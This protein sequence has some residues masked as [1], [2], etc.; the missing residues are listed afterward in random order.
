M[1]RAAKSN[2]QGRKGGER[3]DY[4][5][6]KVGLRYCII[7]WKSVMSRKRDRVQLCCGVEIA[8]TVHREHTIQRSEEEKERI[9]TCSPI[10]ASGSDK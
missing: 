2:F 1:H 4:I 7:L 9:T 8:Y 5:G 3:Y 10:F 6:L